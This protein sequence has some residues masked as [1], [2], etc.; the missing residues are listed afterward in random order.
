MSAGARL[1]SSGWRGKGYPLLIIARR[2]RSIDLFD[3]RLRQADDVCPLHPPLADIDFDFAE[4]RVD[5][6]ENQ[7]VNAGEHDMN[8]SQEIV[9]PQTTK[10]LDV[11]WGCV[12]WKIP[13]SDS[14]I[15]CR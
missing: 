12:G 13:W 9:K 7:R 5:A 3:R 6:A 14:R 1:I 8:V 11:P 15:S 10:P 4:Q 2:T